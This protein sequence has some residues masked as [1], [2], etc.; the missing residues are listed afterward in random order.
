MFNSDPYQLLQFGLAMIVSLSFHELAHARTALAFG[1]PTAKMMGRVTL[2]PLAHLD[3]LGS[4]LFLMAGG[5]GWAKPVP[6]NPA[7]LDP[8]RLGDFLVSLAGPMANFGL[9]VVGAMLLRLSDYLPVWAI[10]H[11]FLQ[12]TADFLHAHEDFLA[13]F[14]W[15]NLSLMLFNMIPL[16]PLDGHH[17]QREMLPARLR[18]PFMDWQMAYGRYALIGLMTLSFFATKINSDFEAPLRR[19]IRYVGEP[20]YQWLV[21]A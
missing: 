2:N 8:P 6:V 3:P 18:G 21:Y 9:A 16:Y 4:V 1:D 11:P 19:L 15:C 7:N 20:I 5:L 14:V 12:S 17:L 10:D 13:L